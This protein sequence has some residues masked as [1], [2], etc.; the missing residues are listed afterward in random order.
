MSQI[1]SINIIIERGIDLVSMGNYKSSRSEYIYYEIRKK[2]LTGIYTPNTRLLVLEVAKEFEVSQAPV[3]EA[4]ERLKQEGLLIGIKNKGSIISKIEQKEI[5]DVYV[6][7]ELMENY[8]M[9]VYLEKRLPD[10]IHHLESIY[11]EM[12]NSAENEDLLRLIELDMEFHQFFYERSGNTEI[13]RVWKN[14]KIKVMR[15]IVT[16][17]QLY[18]PNLK[19]VADTHLELID[20]LKNGNEEIILDVFDSHIK[21]VWWRMKEKNKK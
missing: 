20:A 15:F 4:F 19:I 13:L 12:R 9:R 18:Y 3:R 11:H 8:V 5:E 6:L 10:D 17:N 21:E 7:R 2:I 1:L 14:L 16:T